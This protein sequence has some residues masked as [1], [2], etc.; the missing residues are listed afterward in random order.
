MKS[1]S[2]ASLPLVLFTTQGAVFACC[3]CCWY[4]GVAKKVNF[5]V[6]EGQVLWW[7]FHKLDCD[8][9]SSRADAM[10]TEKEQKWEKE[11]KELKMPKT[12]LLLLQSK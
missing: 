11:G 7:V 1:A 5:W 12:L 10:K 4:S 9:E 2:R 8:R 3:L 6:L